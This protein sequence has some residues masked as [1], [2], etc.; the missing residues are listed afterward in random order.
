MSPRPVWLDFFSYKERHSLLLKISKFSCF[1]FFFCLLFFFYFEERRLFQFFKIMKNIFISLSFF[2]RR[3]V[4]AIF[5]FFFVVSS[6]SCGGAT[7]LNLLYTDQAKN[8]KSIFLLAQVF[9]LSPTTHLLLIHS[10]FFQ[11][12][13]N[14]NLKTFKI[15]NSG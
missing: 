10:F 13:K 12:K 1:V 8:I 4:D 11:I 14:L 3:T 5:T 9:F 2:L 6:S 7:L 15:I